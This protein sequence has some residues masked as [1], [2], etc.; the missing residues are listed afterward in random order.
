MA[1]RRARLTPF[2]RLLLVTRIIEE[3]RSVAVTAES[4]GISRATAHKWLRQFRD[5]GLARRKKTGTRKPGARK[6]STRKTG[7]RR[8][9]RRRPSR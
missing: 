5:E 2:S 4:M 3:G 8:T 7:A 1:H 6:T 9:A